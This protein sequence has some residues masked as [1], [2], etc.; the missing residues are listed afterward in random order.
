MSD[1]TGSGTRKK[2][3]SIITSYSLFLIGLFLMSMGIAMIA[4]SGLGTT[5]ISSVNYVLSLIL[6]LSFGTITFIMA[7]LYIVLQFFIY[8]SHFRLRDLSQVLVAPLLGVF[9]DLGMYIFSLLHP[10]TYLFRFGMLIAGCLI[11]GF[12]TVVMVTPNVIINPMEGGIKAIAWKT[13]EGIR[14]H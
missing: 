9:I 13:G 14:L 10:E 7:L 2:W 4:S 8:R 5:P 1:T 11:L 3:V 6:P 12:G